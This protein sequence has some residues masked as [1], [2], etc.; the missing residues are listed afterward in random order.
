[1]NTSGDD[2][3]LAISIAL[4]RCFPASRELDLFSRSKSSL[5]IHATN[6]L[7]Y[8]N[9]NVLEMIYVILFINDQLA[10]EIN[11]YTAKRRI[12]ITRNRARKKENSFCSPELPP[13][14][15]G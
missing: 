15:G 2:R 3:T 4:S 10:E 5:K 14:S 9:Y 13:V 6:T 11:L 12:N 1:M 8:Q 7:S